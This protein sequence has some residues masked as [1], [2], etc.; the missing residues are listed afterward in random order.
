M[1]TYPNINNFFPSFIMS[2]GLRY[3]S[4]ILHIDKFIEWENNNNNNVSKKKIETS[5][6][7]CGGNNNGISTHDDGIDTDIPETFLPLWPTL[8]ALS[9]YNISGSLRQSL[10]GRLRAFINFE[11]SIVL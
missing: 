2:I 5:K 9:V 4:H 10:G 7:F 3:Y 6:A 11:C 1:G 8:E